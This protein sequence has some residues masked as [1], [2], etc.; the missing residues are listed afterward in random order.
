MDIV[1]YT[2]WF[3]LPGYIITRIINTLCPARRASDAINLLKC[4]GYSL[5]DVALWIWLYKICIDCNN[6]AW[7]YYLRITIVVALTSALTGLLLG[8]IRYCECIR[9][10]II[11][12]FNIQIEKPIPTAWDNIFST[13]KNGCWVIVSLGNGKQIGGRF[14]TKSHASSDQDYRDLFL[15]ET[16]EV[17]EN[18]WKKVNNTE[19]VW[20]SPSEIKKLE[21][22]GDENNERNEKE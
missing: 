14:A 19:G 17:D 2:A 16:Y 3:V 21:F 20:I 13:R 12:V 9:W 4:I 10:L 22:I 18:G 8:L 15:E 6:E 7:W 5:L 11:N 1:I